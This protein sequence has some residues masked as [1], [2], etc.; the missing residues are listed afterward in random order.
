MGF[1][2]RDSLCGSNHVTY[3]PVLRH[4]NFGHFVRQ[5]EEFEVRIARITSADAYV[6]ANR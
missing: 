4:G 5:D 3:T 1:S 6:K 2:S